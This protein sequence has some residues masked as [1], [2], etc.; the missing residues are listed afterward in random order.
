MKIVKDRNKLVK[1][2]NEVLKISIGLERLFFFMLIFMVLTHVVSCIWIITANFSDYSPDTW[3]VRYGY[4]NLSNYDLYIC[5]F[6][7]TITTITTV[8]FGDISGYTIAEK[9]LCIVIMIFGVI[10]FSFATGSLSSLISNLDT[11][12]AKLKQKI[13]TLN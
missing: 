5:A 3:V 13:S 12:E 10:S 1:Y 6:Y 8:G 7:F 4:E 11:S 9:I 2:F